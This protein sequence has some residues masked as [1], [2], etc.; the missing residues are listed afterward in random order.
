MII[1]FIIVIGYFVISAF[2]F[3]LSSTSEALAFAA[4][5]GKPASLV[6]MSSCFSCAFGSYLF[7]GAAVR[8]PAQGC[9][10]IRRLARL[11]AAGALSVT[12]S[13]WAVTEHDRSYVPWLCTVAMFR[14]CYSKKVIKDSRKTTKKVELVYFRSFKIH[15][16]IPSNQI[17]EKI[18]VG[19]WVFGT[20]SFLIHWNDS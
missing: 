19:C 4:G 17:R 20:S 16:F 6:R 18:V 10:S 14:H 13:R 11:S 7:L 1:I 3:G 8:C 9:A 15:F 5:A 12:Q 2:G